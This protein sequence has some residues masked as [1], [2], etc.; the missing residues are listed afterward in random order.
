MEQVYYWVGL[1]VFWLS[2]VS[3]ILA[4]G[5]L[6]LKNIFQSAQSSFRSFLIISKYPLER[7]RISQSS[8]L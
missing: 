3:G 2:A 8:N 1:V 4:L 7:K 6:L 5:V